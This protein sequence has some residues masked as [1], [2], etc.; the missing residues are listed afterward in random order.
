MFVRLV[1]RFRYGK[2]LPP[3][4]R[5]TSIS[6]SKPPSIGGKNQSICLDSNSVFSPSNT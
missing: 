6:T 2:P 5:K 4:Q 3:S 1:K